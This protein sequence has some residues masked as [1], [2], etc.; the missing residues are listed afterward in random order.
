MSIEQ[1]GKFA[2]QLVFV[3]CSLKVSSVFFDCLM[4][5]VCQHSLVG[6]SD[7]AP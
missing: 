4:M 5:R 3:P 7:L 2:C 1:I 6:V